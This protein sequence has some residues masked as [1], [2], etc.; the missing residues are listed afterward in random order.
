MSEPILALT[1][2]RR[3]I[4]EGGRTRPILSGI[5]LV[6]SPGQLVALVG[7]SGCGKTTLLSVAGALDADYQGEARL[8]GQDLRQLNDDARTRLRNEQL[9]FVFQA[10]HLL[11]HLSVAENV[12][13]PLW[14]RDPPIP[15][16]QAN[17]QVQAR[18]D[19]VGLGDRGNE[20]VRQLSGGE[21]QRVAIARALVGGPKLLLAD[22]PTGNLD[23]VTGAKIAELFEQ[24][25]KLDCAV[26]I[27]T[28]D[29]SLAAR[30]DQVIELGVP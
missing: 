23:Q 18:L 15:E 20:S 14:L 6:V 12:A 8:L 30:A 10:F 1:G 2:I 7:P 26:L 9:G 4:Q 25:R 22:E 13:V 27:A 3:E 24:I 17:L 29:R 16:V 11:E 28:H 19:E 21:R 5:D